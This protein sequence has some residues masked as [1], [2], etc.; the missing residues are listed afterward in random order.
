MGEQPYSE[1]V[2]YGE[3]WELARILAA[4]AGMPVK[5]RLQITRNTPAHYCEV[6]YHQDRNYGTSAMMVLG[7]F[8]GGLLGFRGLGSFRRI[9]EWFEFDSNNGKPM[10]FILGAGEV[11]QGWDVCV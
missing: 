11:I 1:T 7:M 3:I 2:S 5:T 10:Q 9:G 4:N 8:V 6:P